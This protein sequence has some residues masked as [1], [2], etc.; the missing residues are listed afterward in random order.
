MA[1]FPVIGSAEILHAANR[2]ESITVIF[3]NNAIY[4]MTG[5]Q[6]APTTLIG[7][8]STTTP[9]G[10]SV[11]NEGYPAR[12]ISQL[13]ATLEAPVYIERVALGD[14]PRD[15]TRR[16]GRTESPRQSGEAAGFLA[17]GSAIAFPD[18]LENGSGGG[19]ALGSG[20][21]DENLPSG[22]FPRSY[23]NRR[24]ASG[25][26]SSASASKRCRKFSD[27]PTARLWSSPAAHCRPPSICA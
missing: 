22:R 23:A 20:R 15:F 18:D 4:G 2:G 5:G 26:C 6:M 12:R 7:Q 16:P 14:N 11:L 1:I 24:A 10:R 13:L 8:K 19:A 25:P 21:D 27:S 3:I 17:G 9:F